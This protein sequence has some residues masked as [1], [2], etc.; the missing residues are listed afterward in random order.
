MSSLVHKPVEV[1]PKENSIKRS[2][3][4]LLLGV[5]ILFKFLIMFVENT[6]SDNTSR[7]NYLE[8]Y[9][10]GGTVD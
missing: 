9:E 7:K 5:M 3:I 2:S 1:Y 10:R 8:K 4:L 6:D